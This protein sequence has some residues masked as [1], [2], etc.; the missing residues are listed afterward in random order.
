VIGS[1]RGDEKKEDSRNLP[2]QKGKK[3]A[4][5]WLFGKSREKKPKSAN[6]LD[7]NLLRVDYAQK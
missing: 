3:C 4:G 2:G 1:K 5:K 7:R 6:P